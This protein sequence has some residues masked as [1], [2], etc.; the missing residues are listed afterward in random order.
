MRAQSPSGPARRAALRNAD[1]HEDGVSE[2]KVRGQSPSAPARR[3][4]L[5]TTSRLDDGFSEQRS[6]QSPS[7]AP[8]RVAFMPD[9]FDDSKHATSSPVS[10]PSS[11]TRRVAFRQPEDDLSMRQQRQM[12]PSRGLQ[13]DLRRSMPA[14]HSAGSFPEAVQAGKDVAHEDES[15]GHEASH[16]WPPAFANPEVGSHVEE[17]GDSNWEDQAE[18]ERHAD[19]CS[20][21]GDADNESIQSNLEQPPLGEELPAH[22]VLTPC[23]DS[24]LGSESTFLSYERDDADFRESH[25]QP[26]PGW[27]LEADDVNL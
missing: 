20:S 16:V 17:H 10:S 3:A 18:L 19:G 11:A 9:V 2:Q 25:L 22:S 27:A 4:A 5:K 21:D 7:G 14:W 13:P 23:K 24:E 12:S 6:P 8:R 26:P 15:Y 1:K